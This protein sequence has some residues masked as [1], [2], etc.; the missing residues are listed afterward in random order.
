M[1]N[2]K[3]KKCMVACCC[4]LSASNCSL[5]DCCN[6]PQHCCHLSAEPENNCTPKNE[7]EDKKLLPRNLK[8]SDISTQFAETSDNDSSLAITSN[9][10]RQK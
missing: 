8:N 5:P 4:N 6:N 9:S 10:S 1:N 2:E 3:M 7:N